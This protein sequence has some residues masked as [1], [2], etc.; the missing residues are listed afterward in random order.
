MATEVRMENNNDLRIFKEFVFKQILEVEQEFELLNN[1][2]KKIKKSRKDP[3]SPIGWFRNLE[4][5]DFYFE[6]K[7][8]KFSLIIVELY[9]LVEQA[10]QNLH[11]SINGIRLDTRNLQGNTI[12]LIEEALSSKIIIEKTIYP[13]AILRN[14]V[15]HELLDIKLGK[16]HA[17]EKL[18]GNRYLSVEI[19][20]EYEE[21][22]SRKPKKIISR[23]IQDIKDYIGSITF[24]E[25]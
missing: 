19:K 18:N 9:A 22:F 12:I 15:L 4:K 25:V 6:R 5:D 2:I 8:K 17:I 3:E 23:M 14:S 10:M 13:L 16:V 24:K 1:E 7:E 20:R 21:I 11:A